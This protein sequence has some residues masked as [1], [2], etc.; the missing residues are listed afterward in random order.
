MNLDQNILKAILKTDSFIHFLSN[1]YDILLILIAYTLI[2][3]YNSLFVALYQF[4]DKEYIYI[5]L[6]NKFKFSNDRKKHSQRNR[7]DLFS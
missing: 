6:L 2:V 7:N 3:E 1:N 4:R 5:Y